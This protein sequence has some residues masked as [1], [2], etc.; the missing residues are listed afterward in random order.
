MIRAT[1]V[2]KIPESLA[3]SCTNCPPYDPLQIFDPEF[4]ELP[5][6]ELWHHAGGYHL[7]STMQSACG[8]VI[9]PYAHRTLMMKIDSMRTSMPYSWYVKSEFNAVTFHILYEIHENENS[10]C[11][12]GTGETSTSMRECRDFTK[13]YPTDVICQPSRTTTPVIAARIV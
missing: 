9:V 8:N 7:K 10:A 2:A 13:R 6:G 11:L 1:Q 12:T 5:I 3:A 4:H